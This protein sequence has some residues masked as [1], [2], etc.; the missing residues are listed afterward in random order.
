MKFV[1]CVDLFDPKIVSDIKL[2]EYFIIMII[3]NRTDYILIRVF[4]LRTAAAV[5]ISNTWIVS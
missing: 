5:E 4:P 3:M 1:L 2:I